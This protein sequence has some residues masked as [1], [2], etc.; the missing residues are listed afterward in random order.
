MLASNLYLA[1]MLV[2]VL[3]PAIWSLMFSLLALR[4]DEP[5]RTAKWSEYAQ[6]MRAL[7]LLT[8][9]AWW[10]VCTAL[11]AFDPNLGPIPDWPRWTILILPPTVGI[12]AGRLLTSWV[13]RKFDTRHWTTTDQ[14]AFTMWRTLSSTVPLLMFAA[15]I[16]AIDDLRVAGIVWIACA[17]I[18]ALFATLRLRAAEGFKPRRVKSGDLFKQSFAM[19]QKM[20]LQLKG[21]FIVP[22]GRGR[23]MNA[24]SLPGYIGMTDICV[25]RIKGAQRDF[26]IGHELAHIRLHHGGKKLR[27]IAT[28]YLTVAALSFVLA[29]LSIVE[30]VLSKSSLILIPVLFSYYVSR[31]FEFAADRAAVEFTGEAEPA[32]RALAALYYYSGVPAR[33]GSFQGLFFTHPSLEKRIDAIASICKV[34]IENVEKIRR[35]FDEETERLAVRN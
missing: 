31:R 3:L 30:Q 10:S 15:G 11:F 9:P 18:L 16:D 8:V 17:T 33:R 5:A 14:I 12:V 24:F 21:I 28:V 23:L 26:F 13:S 32:I 27:I 22:A 1:S 4:R 20:G 29:H 7:N 6:T 34:P 35:Q 25:H 2:A 19:A